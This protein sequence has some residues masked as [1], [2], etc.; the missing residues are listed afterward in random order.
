M[1]WQNAFF[2]KLYKCTTTSD[3]LQNIFAASVVGPR[4]L[5]VILRDVRSYVDYPIINSYFM[6]KIEVIDEFKQW[7]AKVYNNDLL[8]NYIFS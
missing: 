4:F 7:N 2:R 5:F 8:P 3:S 6:T 1:K